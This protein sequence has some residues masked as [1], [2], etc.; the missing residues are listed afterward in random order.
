YTDHQDIAEKIL[1]SMDTGT[2]YWNCCDR[3]SARLPWSGRNHSGIGITL[4]HI[5]IRT[6]THPKAYHLQNPK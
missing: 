5:G 6:F 3:V 2:V 1:R 4:S